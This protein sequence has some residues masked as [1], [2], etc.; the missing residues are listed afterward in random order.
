MAK[1]KRKHSRAHRR[2]GAFGSKGGTGLKLLAVAGGFFAGP[3][4]NGWVDKV[5]PKTTPAG[6]TTPVPNENIGILGEVG[7]G[8]LLLMRRKG[9]KASTYT[10]LAGGVLAGAGLRR[11]AKKMGMMSGYQSV[12]VIGRHRMTGYQSVP[13]IGNTMTPPQLA[14]PARPAQLQGYNVGAYTSAGSGVMNGCG[15]GITGSAS[16]MQ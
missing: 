4:I 15:S 10:A 1:R 16:Y 7:L 3:T 5:L 6:S 13:V 2:V 14:G 8:G 11:L 12:P 9:G